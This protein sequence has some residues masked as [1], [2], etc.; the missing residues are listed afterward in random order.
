[1]LL[2]IEST[3]KVL[4]MVLWSRTQYKHVQKN[5]TPHTH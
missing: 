1:M 5:T 3:M 4:W 2:E